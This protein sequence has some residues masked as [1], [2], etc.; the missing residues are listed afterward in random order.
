M[1]RWPETRHFVDD[2]FQQQLRRTKK[3]LTEKVLF[4]DVK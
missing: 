1:E 2:Q 3:L 4:T